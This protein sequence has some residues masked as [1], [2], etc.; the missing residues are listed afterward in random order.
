[1]GCRRSVSPSRWYVWQ[2]SFRWR[3]RN[4]RFAGQPQPVVRTVVPFLVG[5]MDDGSGWGQPQ[6]VVRMAVLSSRVRHV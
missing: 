1:M 4:G 5:W 2:S 3:S 6:P